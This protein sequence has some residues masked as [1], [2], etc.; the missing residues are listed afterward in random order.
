MQREDRVMD[1]PQGTIGILSSDL[2]RWTQFAQCLLAAGFPA[3]TQIRWC[4]GEWIAGAVNEIIAGMR[5]DDAW[6]SIFADDHQFPPDLLFRLLDH[7]V[8][9]VTPLVNLRKAPY[10]PSLF[11]ETEAGYRAYTWTELA[12]KTGLLPVDT[13]GGPCAI[14]RRRVLDALGPPW[15]QSDPRSPVWPHE[16]LYF[17][18]RAR[19]LGFQPYVDLDCAIGHCIPAVT[20]PQRLEDGSYGIRLSSYSDIGMLL[21]EL[22]PEDPGE[23]TY[24]A[25]T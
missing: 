23:T 11:H 22:L 2:A 17:F 10:A 20:T 7:D 1:Y 9:I 19:Q 13:C 4:S 15:F 21:P 25:Y 6:L 3:G 24:H 8:D 12:G 14:I 18:S 5:P 16:D